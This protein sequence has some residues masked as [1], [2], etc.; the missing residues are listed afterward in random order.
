MI[1][2]VGYTPPTKA[3]ARASATRRTS[4]VGGAQFVDALNKAEGVNAAGEV[5]AVGSIAALGGVGALI[6]AQEVSEEEVHRKRAY[7]RGRMTIDTLE[8]L[9][10]GLLS[11][12]LSMNT[13]RALEKLVTEERALVT[14]PQLS[15]ILDDIEL[16]AAVELA[17][18]E[19]AGI[20][21]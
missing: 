5:D 17:K 13:I 14:D 6:G 9:R 1:D 20:R 8:Q 3:T 15:A 10:D 19:V 21:G 12:N 11:G 18:L 7:K 16:R 4:G 2:K